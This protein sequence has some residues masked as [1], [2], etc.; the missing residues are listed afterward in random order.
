MRDFFLEIGSFFVDPTQRW[1][2]SWI[3][4]GIWGFWL[5]RFSRQATLLRFYSLLLWNLVLAPR[6]L[7]RW[8]NV[9]L[10]LLR[11]FDRARPALF[12]L[13]LRL[14]RFWLFV[15]ARLLLLLLIVGVLVLITRIYL[16]LVFGFFGLR[17][18]IVLQLWITARFRNLTCL[19]IGLVVHHMFGESLTKVGLFMGFRHRVSIVGVG[20]VFLLV[21]FLQVC[22]VLVQECV[23]RAYVR[24]L[25]IHIAFWA[26]TVTLSERSHAWVLER[27]F[28][29]VT[30]CVLGLHVVKLV[31]R[32]VS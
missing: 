21:K 20:V 15:W 24:A 14:C 12:I 6:V 3:T 31:L 22:V 16:I 11:L 18:N 8:I 10:W 30:S 25:H 26:S 13:G 17:E 32:R 27:S 19:S 2:R 5:C 7:L 23:R 1:C 4:S 28:I 29:G 9:E